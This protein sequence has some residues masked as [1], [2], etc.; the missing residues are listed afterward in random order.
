MHESLVITCTC[1]AVITEHI[2]EHHVGVHLEKIVKGGG[3]G[4]MYNCVCFG[5]MHESLVITY[6]YM[7]RCDN[8]IAMDVNAFSVYRNCCGRAI[9]T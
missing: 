6:L 7:S 9:R 3:G 5:Y 8:F 4:V 1:Y 2:G